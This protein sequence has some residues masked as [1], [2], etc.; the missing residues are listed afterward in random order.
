MRG[1]SSASQWPFGSTIRVDP[2]VLGSL[3]GVHGNAAG[4]S[5]CW[6]HVSCVG[7]LLGGLQRFIP[8]TPGAVGAICQFLGTP[9]GSVTELFLDTLPLRCSYRTWPRILRLVQAVE[10]MLCG[11]VGTGF[12]QL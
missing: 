4:L 2:R 6:M 11:D 7:S 9:E 1:T 12:L 10:R 8:C 5:I 3:R